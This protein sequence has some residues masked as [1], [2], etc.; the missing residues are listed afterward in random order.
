MKISL[1]WDDTVTRDVKL[2]MDFAARALARGHDV[3]VV[4]MRYEREV[5]DMKEVMHRFAGDVFPII[6]TGRQQKRPFCEKLG[7]VPDVWIDDC[8]EFIVANGGQQDCLSC[9]G[10]GVVRVQGEKNGE[11]YISHVQC[12]ACTGTGVV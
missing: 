4:T 11:L 7:W 6:F 10:R 9:S 12:K 2:W 3:R 5:F 1:D 8:P